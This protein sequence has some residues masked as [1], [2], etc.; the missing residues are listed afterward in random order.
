MEIVSEHHDSSAPR[1]GRYLAA[2]DRSSCGEFCAV[3]D[4]G[5][6]GNVE[7]AGESGA[8]LVHHGSPPCSKIA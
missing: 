2:F 4:S 5:D 3:D 6:L 7:N 8:V 1:T